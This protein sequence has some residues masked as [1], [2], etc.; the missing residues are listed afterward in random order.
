M[1]HQGNQDNEQ[2]HLD[3]LEVRVFFQKLTSMFMVQACNQ[4][5]QKPAKLLQKQRDRTMHAVSRIADL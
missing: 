4:K 1:F 5:V 3:H 2:F